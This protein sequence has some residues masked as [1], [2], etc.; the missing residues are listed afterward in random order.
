MLVLGAFGVEEEPTATR[1]DVERV[2]AVV[3]ELAG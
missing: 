2:L 3:R 1:T